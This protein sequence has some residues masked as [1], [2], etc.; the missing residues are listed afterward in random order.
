M[1][2]MTCS[3]LREVPAKWRGAR[4]AATRKVLMASIISA[5]VFFMAISGLVNLCSEWTHSTPEKRACQQLKKPAR[6]GQKY[7]GESGSGPHELV[8]AGPARPAGATGARRRHFTV[9][10][11]GA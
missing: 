7:N 9:E 8:T 5:A 3:A 11:V 2:R 10:R 6:G 1:L 4:P